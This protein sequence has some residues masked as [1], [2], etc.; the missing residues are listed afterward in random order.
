MADFLFYFLAALALG[1]GIAMILNRNSV[2]SVL[3]LVINF[4]CIGGLYLLLESEFLAI[5]QIIVYAGAI[6]VLF[7]FVVML[8]NLGKEESYERKYDT[9]KGL[10]FLVSM[11]FL[12][13]MLYALADV[14]QLSSAASSFS[15][16]KVETI[17]KEMM[18]N[19]LFPFEMVSVVLLA[20]MI[21]AL[22]I[23]RKHN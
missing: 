7:L 5:T 6:M 12:A 23:A 8:L 11:G 2:Y 17:G 15:F 22:I 4:F 3:L 20:A 1:S 13:E 14:R 18:T 16:G 10:A 21:G 9:T 19:Y